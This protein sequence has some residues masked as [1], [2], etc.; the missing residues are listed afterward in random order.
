MDWLNALDVAVFRFINGTLQNAAFDAVMPW[1]SGNALFIPA[2]VILAVMLLWQG[3]PRGRVFVPVLLLALAFADGFLCSGLKELIGRPRPFASLAD[4]HLLVGKGS[5]AAMPSGHATNWAAAT[6]L[7]AVYYRRW[8]W[9]VG[10]LGLLVGFS[11]IYNGVHYPG[12]VLA[13]FVLG[14]GGAAFV[15]WALNAAW[16]AVGR[17]WFP[18]WW[19]RLP[20]LLTPRAAA[21]SVPAGKVLSL[22]THWLRLGYA[23]IAAMLVF[24][25]GYIASDTIE[26]SNDEAYQW[27]WSKHL[28][29]SYF[30]KPPLIAY[31]QWL[32]TTL[33]G[34]NEFGV[35]FLSPLLAA[36]VSM[37][38]LR[39]FAREGMV[40]AG[41]LV[42]VMT[43]AMPLL[44]VGGTL[45]TVDPLNVAFWV[46]AMFAGW[47]AAQPGGT[48]G[49]WLWVGLWMGLGFL[50]KYT[51]LL[52][53][54]CW[55]V[56]F[57]LW[58]PARAHL[59]R[60]G[61]WLAVGVNLLCTLPV[62]IW[63][64]RHSW[65][66]VHHV[67]D[68]AEYDKPLQLTLRFLPD[69]LGAEFGL[70]NPVFFVG[71]VWAAAAFWRTHRRDARLLFFFSMGAPVFVIYTLQSFI[72]RV[73]P[74]WPAP[75]VVPLLVFTVLYWRERWAAPFVRRAFL[76]GLIFG[77]AAFVVLCE[78]RFV[79]KLT[80]QPLPVQL[81]PLHRVRGWRALTEEVMTQRQR[82]LGGGRPV[83]VIADHYS[84][85]SQFTFYD[86]EARAA[87]L[88]R[89]PLVVYA[90]P[91]KAGEP[92]SPRNQFYYW[93]Q[94]DYRS[95]Q[96][97]NALFVASK[98]RPKRAGD[99]PPPA[100][101]PP[102]WLARQF[103][104]VRNLGVFSAG[105]D[106]QPIWW[107]ELYAC[108]GLR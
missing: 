72:G 92:E 2:M 38:L 21:P 1:L 76:G 88:R 52:Q 83:F 53:W 42:L 68:R 74:N 64:A 40:R 75:A 87:A 70:L 36:A 62:V 29:L 11:R 66:T 73:L 95:R 41:V 14:A 45:L 24:R 35:R 102:A 105:F 84:E 16:H 93:P 108:E 34:D 23:L 60:P 32:G 6:F 3:G 43:L 89:E 65:I 100:E 98:S 97:Q 57:L 86:E 37:M 5:N 20:S 10:A 90:R 33:W 96:G 48:L 19:S 91:G 61:P 49:D 26:L 17:R 106:G 99:P 58:A 104:R 59:R 51:A 81:D 69:F 50:S 55:A 46:A 15:A 63:N 103:A 27:L 56:F 78:T 25:L 82:L 71:M 13:G 31:A 12:D 28:A 18:I 77:L 39:F 94:Y 22:D 54:L 67:A 107:V 79:R 85:T 101:P 44:A 8:A 4:V 30:S 9:L 7:V 47:R 80:G